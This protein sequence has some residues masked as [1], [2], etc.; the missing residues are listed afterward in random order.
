MTTKR[1][2]FRLTKE[3]KC[4]QARVLLAAN[5]FAIPVTTRE[6]AVAMILSDEAKLDLK[7][8]RLVVAFD[9]SDSLP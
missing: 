9:I 6:T 8:R 2:P 5:D 3:Q 7:S 4:D 1:K